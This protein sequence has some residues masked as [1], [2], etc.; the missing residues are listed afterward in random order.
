MAARAS[1]Q[2]AN[3]V[4]NPSNSFMQKNLAPLL[5]QTVKTRFKNR[6]TQSTRVYRENII[7]KG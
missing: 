7:F 6:V 3:C 1:N 5:A 4:H 2:D